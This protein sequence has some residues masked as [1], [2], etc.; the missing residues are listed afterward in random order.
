MTKASENQYPKVTFAEGAAPGTPSAGLVI[1][2]AKT[3][4]L[5][6]AKD[7]V[8][9]EKL[10]SVGG[11]VGAHVYHST[12]QTLTNNANTT[13]AFDSERY[14]TS[15]IHDTVTNNSRLTIPTTGKWRIGYQGSTTATVTSGNVQII[16]SSGTTT[17][18]ITEYIQHV[19]ATID[20][21]A[22][23][24]DYFTVTMFHNSGTDRTLGGTS[25]FSA[26]FWCQFLG[27]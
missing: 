26:E 16:H 3:D 12:T 18:A 7:D 6:Y 19:N 1:A 4:G 2:Y 22:T 17:V 27:A 9:T 14:D 10:L 5:L 11:F 23:A 21:S 20:V 15:A 8:G 25:A 13:I 24:A